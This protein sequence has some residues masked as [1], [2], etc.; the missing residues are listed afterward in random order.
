MAV[1]GQSSNNNNN[2]TGNNSGNDNNPSNNNKSNPNEEKTAQAVEVV[3]SAVLEVLVKL[4]LPNQRLE[5]GK[6]YGEI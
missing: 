3:P 2:N 5:E 1:L 6:E 4:Q